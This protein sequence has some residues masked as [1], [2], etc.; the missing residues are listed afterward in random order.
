MQCG[1]LG[2]VK[3]LPLLS[4]YLHAHLYAHLCALRQNSV[5]V[6]PLHIRLSLPE[7]FAT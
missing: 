4:N 7:I 3:Q 1:R 5:E 2:G 6:F